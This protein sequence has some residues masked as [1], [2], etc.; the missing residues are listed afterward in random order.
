MDYKITTTE[1]IRVI[2]KIENISTENGSNFKQIPEFWARSM[3]DGLF[4]KVLDIVNQDG[5]TKAVLGICMDFSPDQQNFN[6][7]IGAESKIEEI[8]GDLEE[9]IIP[10]TTWVIFKSQGEMPGAI[11]DLTKRIYKEWFPSTK[12]IH[13]G[14][15]EMEVYLPDNCFE[16]WV[17]VKTE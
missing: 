12:Y 5:M 1:P 3:K 8:T 7:M 6:Y 10:A 15:P 4:Q 2:G 9:I 11:Q 17:P 16:I 13:A 14:T